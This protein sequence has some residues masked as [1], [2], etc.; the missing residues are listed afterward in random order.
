MAKIGNESALILKLA[1]DRIEQKK[2]KIDETLSSMSLEQRKWYLG[3][4]DGLYTTQEILRTII[5]ELQEG[6]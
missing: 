1:D 5:I 3:K 4:K 2:A 6:R